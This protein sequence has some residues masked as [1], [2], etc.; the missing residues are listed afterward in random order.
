[1]TASGPQ[2][3]VGLQALEVDSEMFVVFGSCKGWVHHEI[4]AFVTHT[5][6][7]ASSMRGPYNAF[8]GRH[9]LP[10]VNLSVYVNCIRVS[11][12]TT[13]GIHVSNAR[14][15]IV[16]EITRFWVVLYY[17]LHRSHV[18]IGGHCS[19]YGAQDTTP[20]KKQVQGG[21]VHNM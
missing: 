18:V 20:D 7:H 4:L 19:V 17:I 2:S 10:T 1:M 3:G 6:H 13:G 15:C 21:I 16:R 12:R 14:A 5:V 9:T 11:G 8:L